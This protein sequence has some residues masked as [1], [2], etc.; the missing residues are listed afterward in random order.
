[1]ESYARERNF[2]PLIPANWYIISIDVIKR[3]EVIRLSSPPFLY[4]I[5]L[6]F[7]YLYHC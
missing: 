2:D 5:F 4:F 1:M 6:F 7:Y 3:H